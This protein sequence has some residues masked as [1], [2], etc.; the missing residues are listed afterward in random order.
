MSTFIHFTENFK[1][2]EWKLSNVCISPLKYFLLYNICTYI[3]EVR[4]LNV[5]IFITKKR[6]I[7]ESLLILFFFS[8][9]FCFVAATAKKLQRK[10]ILISMNFFSIS[11]F[12][13]STKKKEEK[14]KNK[15]KKK[16][17]FCSPFTVVDVKAG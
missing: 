14:E 15:Q 10:N 17:F 2:R 16:I 8:V 3:K 13:F 5:L 7:P 11:G 1:L 9:S 4:K 12:Y 6:I